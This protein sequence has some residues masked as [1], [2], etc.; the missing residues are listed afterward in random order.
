MVKGI[1]FIHLP[2]AK[3]YFDKVTVEIL[4]SALTTFIVNKG[5]DFCYCKKILTFVS[6]GSNLLLITMNFFLILSN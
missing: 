4:A 1:V 5:R 2:L 6:H 3:I